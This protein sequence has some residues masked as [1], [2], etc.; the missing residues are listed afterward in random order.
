LIASVNSGVGEFIRGW[1]AVVACFA[2][3]IF[4]WGFGSYGQGIYLEELH[5]VHGWPTSMLGSVATIAFLFS[6]GVL[7]WV[8]A[9][10][11]RISPR[12]VLLLL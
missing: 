8:G 11:E 5:R 12:F 10:V 4:A 2:A 3:A 7:P 6:A 1:R 9:A